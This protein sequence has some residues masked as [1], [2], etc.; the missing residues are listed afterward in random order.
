MK[1]SRVPSKLRKG[2][3]R[4]GQKDADPQPEEP[5]LSSGAEEEASASRSS[6]VQVCRHGRRCAGNG[7]DQDP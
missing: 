4:N 6:S 1:R 7:I 3:R 2:D 5:G